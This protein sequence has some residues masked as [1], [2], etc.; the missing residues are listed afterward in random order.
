MRRRLLLTIGL[1]VLGACLVAG[2]AGGQAAPDVVGVGET[3]VEI[4]VPNG[5]QLDPIDALPECSNLKDDDS[6]GVKDLDDPDCTDPLDTTESGSNGIPY[7]DQPPAG[8]GG[9]NG[10]G[11]NGGP[12]TGPRV[13]GGGGPK[14]DGGAVGPSGGGGRGL[15]TKPS[16]KPHGDNQH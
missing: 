3:G 11:G 12:S 14:P 15:G 2:T 10:G 7:P 5:G 6:D 13:P 8:G 1:A 16:H 9:G 4:N